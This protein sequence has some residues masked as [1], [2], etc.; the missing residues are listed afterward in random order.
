[1]GIKGLR[2][3]KPFFYG[4][5]GP[6]IAPD[7]PVLPGIWHTKPRP[8]AGEILCVAKVV[9]IRRIIG[10]AFNSFISSGLFEESLDFTYR[11]GFHFRI[12]PFSVG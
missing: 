2:V 7:M 3:R 10:I 5:Y 9:V 1:M 11:F 4:V 8:K 6:P 12:C